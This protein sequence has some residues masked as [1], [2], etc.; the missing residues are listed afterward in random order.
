[1][2]G[3]RTVGRRLPALV[4][5]VALAAA[6]PAPTPTRKGPPTV[7]RHVPSWKGGKVAL[8]GLLRSIEELAHVD[9]F[10]P[11]VVDGLRRTAERIE[12]TYRSSQRS[13]H[14]DTDRS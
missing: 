9:N 2:T 14:P 5:G 1:M 7:D 12:T 11:H 10:A 3:S 6:A 4:A 13:D 8:S